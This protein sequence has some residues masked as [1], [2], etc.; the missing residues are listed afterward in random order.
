MHFIIFYNFGQLFLRY[1][2]F[3]V[4]PYVTYFLIQGKLMLVNA[5]DGVEHVFHLEGTGEKPLP[6]ENIVFNTQ[7]KQRYS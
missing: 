7:V 5:A 4:K 2:I 1:P 3:L 6:L